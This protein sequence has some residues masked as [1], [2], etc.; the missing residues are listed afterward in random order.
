M[1]LLT[2]PPDGLQQLGWRRIVLTALAFCLAP[3]VIGG[4]GLAAVRLF[5]LGG[6][7]EAA[8]RAEMLTT[9][10]LI[11]PLIG[12]PVW[13][14]IAAGTW[15]LLRRGSYRLAA[16]RPAGLPCLRRADARRA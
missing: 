8:F 2:S 14:A 7:A 1:S 6:T 12:V 5:D 16:G 11:S 9:L 10:A 13:A 15:W 3:A 4:I